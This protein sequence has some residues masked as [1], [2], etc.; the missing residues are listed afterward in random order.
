MPK[1]AAKRISDQIQAGT[2][3]FG[4]S[5]PAEA[6]PAQEAE[7]EAAFAD[8]YREAGLVPV[9]MPVAAERK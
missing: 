4:V 8:A 3:S 9:Q 1:A 7:I 2:Y 5:V 6:T